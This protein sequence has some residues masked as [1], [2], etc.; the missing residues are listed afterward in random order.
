MTSPDRFVSLAV[1]LVAVSYAVGAPVAF[2]M[3]YR[4]GWV[5]GNL[6]LPENVIFLAAALQLCCSVAI[7][8]RATA[9]LATAA[10]SVV[11]IGVAVSYL[12]S[13]ATLAS[14]PA[15]AYTL[16]QV[17]LGLRLCSE[18]GAARWDGEA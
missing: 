3:E 7:L 6:G 12:R 11:S 16:V 1:V 14:V 2:L 5:S 9:N 18:C 15:L 10:L 13:G 8:F 4:H 17:W